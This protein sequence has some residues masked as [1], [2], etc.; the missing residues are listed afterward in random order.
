MVS[1]VPGDNGE[2][3]IEMQ[4]TCILHTFFLAWFNACKTAADNGDVTDWAA[5]VVSARNI[6]DGTSH[7]ATGVSP[8]KVPDKTYAASGGNI[9][10]SLMAARVIN[11]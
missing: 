2:V 8:A 6:V 4:Q 9:T 1:Y 7:T 3:N 11:Q 10:W 5:G